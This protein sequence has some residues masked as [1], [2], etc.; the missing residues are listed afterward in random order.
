MHDWTFIVHEKILSCTNREI[1]HDFFVISNPVL[2]IHLIVFLVESFELAIPRN[3][4]GSLKSDA[5]FAN[6]Y[7][8][9]NIDQPKMHILWCIKMQ[10]QYLTQ[11]NKFFHKFRSHWGWLFLRSYPNCRKKKK[12]F[13]N[14]NS[15]ELHICYS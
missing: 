15:I 8:S 12:S 11:W 2:V 7:F 1:V 9:V 13:T 6:I 5:T 14:W 10:Q 3:T 4:V